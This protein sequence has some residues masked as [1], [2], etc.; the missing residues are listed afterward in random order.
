MYTASHTPHGM[1]WLKQRDVVVGDVVVGDPAVAAVV[2]VPLRQPVSQQRVHLRP[3]RR[4]RPRLAPHLGDVEPEI[5]ADHVSDPPVELLD[6]EM[7]D[8]RRAELMRRDSA[9]VPSRL[10]RPEPRPVGE[11]GQHVAKHWVLQLRVGSGRR[12]DAPMPP[13]PASSPREDLEHGA[14]G[15]P[16]LDPLLEHDRAL[17]A[18]R[19]PTA[20]ERRSPDVVDH[21]I[22]IVGIAGVDLSGLPRQLRA[23]RVDELLGGLLATCL[24]AELPEQ[25]LALLPGQQL[26]GPVRYPSDPLTARSPVRSCAARYVNTHAS[27]SRRSSRPGCLE[28]RSSRCHCSEA[29]DKPNRAPSLW[30]GIRSRVRISVIG[31]FGSR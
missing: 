11:R 15:H 6:R 21:Q 1:K 20:L 19:A 7:P 25:R 17:G 27:K 28:A 31:T 5:G 13:D 23:D 10:R 24:G 16:L 14:L 4:H 30:S 9:H 3:V 22:R 18:V 26:R 8:E 12:A 29:N 2:D